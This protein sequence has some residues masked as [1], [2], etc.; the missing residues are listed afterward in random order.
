M[1]IQNPKGL[2]SSPRMKPPLRTV[3]RRHAVDVEESRARQPGA[4]HELRLVE[5]GTRG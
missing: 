4:G 1:M 3:W 5:E 2:C